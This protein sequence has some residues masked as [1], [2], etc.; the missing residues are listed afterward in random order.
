MGPQLGHSGSPTLRARGGVPMPLTGALCFQKFPI[1][2]G[3][4]GCLLPPGRWVPRGTHPSSPPPKL[5]YRI[6]FQGPPGRP[7]ARMLPRATPNSQL[8]Q[9][10]RGQ[11]PI[12]PP[13]CPQGASD[14]QGPSRELSSNAHWTCFRCCPLCTGRAG[15][16]IPHLTS[17]P[18]SHL[19]YCVDRP[20]PRG[21]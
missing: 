19:K 7:W 12:W 4:A 2:Q 10:S 18:R 6:P 9:A 1:Q 20:G 14:L 15:S 16:P 17:D 11:T 3:V 8:A 13:L 5:K 21:L